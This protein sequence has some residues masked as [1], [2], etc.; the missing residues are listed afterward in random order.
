MCN[1]EFNYS[2]LS[3]VVSITRGFM[4]ASDRDSKLAA[5]KLLN[6]CG[7]LIYFQRH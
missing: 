6:L 1:E 2:L 7:K 5:N 4:G 3:P